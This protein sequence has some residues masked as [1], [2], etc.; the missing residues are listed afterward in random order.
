MRQSVAHSQSLWLTRV[1]GVE[2]RDI[3]QPRLFDAE[4]GTVLRDTD[5]FPRDC[6]T[7]VGDVKL[8]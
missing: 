7:D 5:R 6:G 4:L 8:S 1:N 3:D 2:R